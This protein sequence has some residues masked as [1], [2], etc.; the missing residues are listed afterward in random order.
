MAA[1]ATE[2]MR[3]VRLRRRAQGKREI[4]LILPDARSEEVRARI[5]E[6][7]TRLDRAHE[8]EALRWVESVAEFDGTEAR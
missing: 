8:E 6:A 2:R 5:A 4:R 1:S 7:V 3:S